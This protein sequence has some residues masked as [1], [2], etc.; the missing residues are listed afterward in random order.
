MGAAVPEMKTSDL[1]TCCKKREV[2]VVNEWRGRRRRRRHE[3][4]SDECWGGGEVRMCKPFLPKAG[5]ERRRRGAVVGVMV[6]ALPAQWLCAPAGW[7]EPPQ[8]PA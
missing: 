5:E 7:A 1:E 6:V 8:C 4:V 2:R 3:A